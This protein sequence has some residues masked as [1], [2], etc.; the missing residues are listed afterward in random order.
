MNA[1]FNPMFCCTKIDPRHSRVKRIAD[2]D[3]PMIGST[4]AIG[5]W[6]LALKLKYYHRFFSDVSD[7]TIKGD[8]IIVVV[9]K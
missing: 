9:I 1:T 6:F 7:N 2:S 8:D 5:N 3:V 4:T